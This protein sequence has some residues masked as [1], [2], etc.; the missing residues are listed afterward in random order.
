MAETELKPCPFCGCAAY[1]WNMAD[2]EIYVVGCNGVSTCPGNIGKMAPIYY[3]KELAIKYW[4]RR[5]D[6]D[7][8]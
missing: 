4:N 8:A 5:V 1:L 6:D 3:T 7:E 2:S